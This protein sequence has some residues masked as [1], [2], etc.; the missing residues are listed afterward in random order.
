MAIGFPK[1]VVL[2]MTLYNWSHES[3]GHQQ[4]SDKCASKTAVNSRTRSRWD[5]SGDS[6]RGTG[7]GTGTPARGTGEAVRL[8]PSPGAGSSAGVGDTGTGNFLSSSGHCG[9]RVVLSG[10]R[11]SLLDSN[12]SRDHRVEALDPE[13]DGLGFSQS[14]GGVRSDR[15]RSKPGAFR[16]TELGISRDSI[17]P[18]RPAKDAQH[19]QDAP[20]SG[21]AISPRGLR[22][23]GLQERVSKRAPADPGSVPATG[24][25]CGSR[26]FDSASVGV[27]QEYSCLCPPSKERDT[28]R[29][30]SVLLPRRLSGPA[31]SLQVQASAHGAESHISTSK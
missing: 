1:S 30:V 21:L 17:C 9:S 25:R 10:H 24:R 3:N 2:K 4:T 28:R 6:Q 14:G 23:G 8:E 16:G 12:H 29:P 26:S 19:D 15:P 31:G 18:S 7:S 5:S 20:L 11:G 13:N 22:C 27:W